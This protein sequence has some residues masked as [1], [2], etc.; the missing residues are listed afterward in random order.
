[1]V[2]PE[3]STSEDE[4]EVEDL[5]P[6]EVQIRYGSAAKRKHVEDEMANFRRVRLRERV[7]TLKPSEEP[8]GL[9]SSTQ[10]RTTARAD[11]APVLYQE[12]LATEELTRRPMGRRPKIAWTTTRQKKLVRYYLSTNLDLQSIAKCLLE[13]DFRPRLFMLSYLVIRCT[14]LTINSIRNVQSH[15]FMLLPDS[16]REWR[17]HRPSS[18]SMQC[19]K[20]Q[21]SSCLSNLAMERAT[22]REA[23]SIHSID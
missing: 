16:R 6:P 22:V 19:S 18:G 15:L 12:G 9:Y 3:S 23:Q 13:D 8:T 17:M 20:V 1:M 4:L 11:P 10:V 14:E 21:D 7:L 2:Y 5:L